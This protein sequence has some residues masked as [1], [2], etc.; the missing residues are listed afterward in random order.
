VEPDDDLAT[1][2]DLMSKNNIS[3]V[4]VIVINNNRLDGIV[5]KADVVKAF[6]Q[7]IT[8]SKLLESYKTFR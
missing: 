3:G 1:A 7:V 5:T 4:P 8:H 6:S 2:A